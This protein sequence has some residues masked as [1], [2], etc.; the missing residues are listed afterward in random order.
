[1]VYMYCVLAALQLPLLFF[2]EAW[3]PQASFFRRGLGTTPPPLL[4]PLLFIHQ[5][6]LARLRRY[7]S[8]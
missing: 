1:M 6:G 3:A 8:A 2:F 4:L 7:P 5:G